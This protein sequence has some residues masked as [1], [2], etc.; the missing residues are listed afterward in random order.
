MPSRTCETCG[1]SFHQGRGRPAKRCAEHLRYGGAHQSLRSA[2]LADAYGQPC[3]RCGHEMRPG[4]ELHLDHQDGG[5]PSDYLGFS[6]AACNLA[7]GGRLAGRPAPSGPVAVLTR[8][9]PLAPH[10][11]I[12]HKPG[13]RCADQARD[14]G[15]WPSRCW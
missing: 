1:R 14:W 12:V 13:C 4:Q 6:H 2:T 15:A 11:E 10:H 8:T 5:G 3:V 9:V 7:A